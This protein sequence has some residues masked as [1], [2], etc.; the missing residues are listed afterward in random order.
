VQGGA[1]AYG[2]SEKAS[3]S[4][5]SQIFALDSGLSLPPNTSIFK[6][7]SWRKGRAPL[8]ASF[9]PVFRMVCAMRQ[10]ERLAGAKDQSGSVG[11]KSGRQKKVRSEK[12]SGQ[13]KLLEGSAR[14]AF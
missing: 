13:L 10:S 11:R 8:M 14:K 9:A 12:V 6:I 4:M 2:R 3:T 5:D 1:H 7:V